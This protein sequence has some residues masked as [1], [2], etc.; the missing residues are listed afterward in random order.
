V[1]T[2]Q[3]DD[4]TSYHS[5]ANQLDSGRIDVEGEMRYALVA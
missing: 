1:P 2:F 3:P 4:G 5:A